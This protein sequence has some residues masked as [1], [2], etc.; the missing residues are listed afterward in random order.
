[1]KTALFST[2]HGHAH[3]DHAHSHGGGPLGW[4]ATVFHWHGHEHQEGAHPAA[5]EQQARHGIQEGLGP[6]RSLA[7]GGHHPGPHL[8]LPEHADGHRHR[9]VERPAAPP[10]GPT[11]RPWDA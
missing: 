7:V 11:V 4:L 8:E 10:H 1:M 9:D 2:G 3:G 5:H 6:E